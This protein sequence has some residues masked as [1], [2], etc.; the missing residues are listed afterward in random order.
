MCR[1]LEKMENRKAKLGTPITTSACVAL[2]ESALQQA[3]SER[4]D[5]GAGLSLDLSSRKIGSIPSEVVAMV[6][7]DVE[8]P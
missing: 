6:K 2:V 1:Q 5:D 4:K 8:R 7:D 3:S